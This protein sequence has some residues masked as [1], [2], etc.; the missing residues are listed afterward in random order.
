MAVKLIRPPEAKDRTA[1]LR[2]LFLRT[3]RQIVNEI[4]R[5]R[6]AGYVDYAETA[7]LERVREILRELEDESWSYVPKMIERIFY[8]SDAAASGYANARTLSAAQ[9]AAVDQLTNNLLGEIAEA[10]E[11]ALKSAQQYFTIARLE[12][13]PY[14][15]AALYHVAAQEASGT[16]WPVSTAEMKRELTNKGITAFVDKAGR[17]W[18]LYD[19]CNMATRTTERQA[20]VAA[21]LTA[22]DHDLWQ[23]VKIGSTCPVCAPLEGRVYSKSGTN[24]D[25]PPLSLAFGKVDPDGAESLENTYLNIH[26]NCLHTLVKYTT[27]G[28]TDR[29]IQRDKDFSD[30]K[31]NPLNR[32]PRTK[33]QIK[34]YQEKERNRRKLLADIRQHREYRSILGADVPKDFA[35]FREMKYNEPEKFDFIKLDYRRRNRLIRNPELKLP[36][37]ENAKAAAEK[38]T[39]YLFDGVHPD[40]LAKGAAFSSR[41]GYSIDNWAGL[42]REILKRAP[43]YPA[44]LKDNNGYGDRY[45]QK[46]VIYGKKG[47]PANVVVGWLH[48]PDGSVSMSSAYIK[49]VE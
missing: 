15:S 46:I 31:K 45:S 10:S 1:F 24:P 28:K 22:D 39:K 37:A 9:M 11:T 8:Q 14:R 38:F 13:D 21:V 4:T 34:A 49:E 12:A 40:G 18:T 6:A 47:I 2:A 26:P 42:R 48:K 30:P 36:N 32:D 20:E 35:K 19:Y 7:A 25:Y 33:K 27:V 43:L 17:K 16:G 5:K 23:I 29:Q 41:L 3:E 44:T